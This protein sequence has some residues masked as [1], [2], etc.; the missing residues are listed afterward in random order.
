[1]AENWTTIAAEVAAGLAEVADVSQSGG[2]PVTLRKTSTTGGDPWDPGS[3]TTTA[4]DSTLTAVETLRQVRDLT[5]TLTERTVR[6]LLV[7]ANSGVAPSDDDM[8]ALGVAADDVEP[9][10]PFEAIDAV[11]ALAPA[12]IAVLY[13]IDLKT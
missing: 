3:G 5:G 2:Y 7:N 9:E 4:V 1:M 13:E 11:R 6:T 10:T 12:G 8:I